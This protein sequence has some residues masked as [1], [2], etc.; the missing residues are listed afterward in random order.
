M[1]KRLK[2]FLWLIFSILCGL[3]FFIYHYFHFSCDQ[4]EIVKLKINTGDCFTIKLSHNG[5][6]GYQ[7]CWINENKC[8][9]VKSV[10]RHYENSWSGDCAGCSS[11]LFWTF[12]G[13]A[14]GIDTIKI[15]ECPPIPGKGCNYFAGDSLRLSGDS[16]V[17][18]Y[19]PYRKGDYTFIV[20]VTD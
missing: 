17:S 8:K 6:T 18:K 14:V 13:I 12:S 1:K 3:G 10:D 9:F 11:L 2:I 5:S 7:K 19:A 15:S 4:G 20:T 16:I